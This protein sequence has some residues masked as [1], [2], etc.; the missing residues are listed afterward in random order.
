MHTLSPTIYIVFT[1]VTAAGVLLQALVL[2]AIYFA[3]RRSSGKL[4]ETLDEV[5]AKAL[6][7]LDAAQNLLEEI[8]PNLKAATSNLAEVSETLRKQAG[9]VNA[10]VESLVDRTNAQIQRADDMVTAAMNAFGQASK[11]VETAISVPVR[12]VS[13]LA[14]GLR[15]GVEVLLGAKRGSAFGQS[16]GEPVATEAT[17]GAVKPGEASGGVKQA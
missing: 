7:A 6:P 5:K 11:A 16:V 17:G 15:V 12:R 9:H 14:R 1:A 13:N 8:S 4:L 10:T 3:V 2:L